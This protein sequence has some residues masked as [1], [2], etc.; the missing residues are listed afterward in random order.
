MIAL[1]IIL[2]CV[3][4]VNTILAVEEGPITIYTKG[5]F[6]RI[7]RNNGIVI[8]TAHA[9]YEENGIEYPVYCLNRELH[10]VGDYTM[11]YTIIFNYPFKSTVYPS[12]GSSKLI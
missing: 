10:G 4:L 1:I 7:I 2:N 3:V 8:K 5:Y 6:K 11:C 9:V 12:I